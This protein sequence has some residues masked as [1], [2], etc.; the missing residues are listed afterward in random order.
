MF[1][2][3]LSDADSVKLK[4]ALQP[5]C[6]PTHH[7]PAPT[8]HVSACGL[9]QAH[10]PE[11][12]VHCCDVQHH[13]R[14]CAA[15]HL[16]EHAGIAVD[17]LES[18]FAHFRVAALDA[19]LGGVHIRVAPKP[20]VIVKKVPQVDAVLRLLDKALDVGVQVLAC[21]CKPAW[22]GYPKGSLGS[23]STHPHMRRGT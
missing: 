13:P 20:L 23:R 22:R 10:A 3:Q 9:Q 4:R 2:A 12:V 16:P 14:E 8:H 7:P 6:T 15:A 17:V 1:A 11:F 19:E 18:L 21:S 5:Y